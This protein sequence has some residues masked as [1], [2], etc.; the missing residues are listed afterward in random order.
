M[1]HKVSVKSVWLSRAE[2]RTQE[3]GQRTESSLE[4]ADEQIRHWAQTAPKEGSYHKT[5]FKVTWEDGETYA[6]RYDLQFGDYKKSNL[7]GSH[8]QQHLAFLA[9][10]VCPER[11]TRE[12]YETYL[13]QYG[14]DTQRSEILAFLQ[15][16]EL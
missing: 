11:M 14:Y 1:S 10:L 6:G 4:A 5:D 3:I 13:K 12:Q 7:L 2:G 15:N 16:Y 9:G 8:I